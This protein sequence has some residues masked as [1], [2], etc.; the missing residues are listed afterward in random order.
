MFTRAAL[1][2]SALLVFVAAPL[3]AADTPPPAK[4]AAG[5]M[6]PDFSTFD[7]AGKEVRLADY[8]GKVLILDFWAT[9]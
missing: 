2:V 3:L 5:V 9:W 1:A 4:L 8:R 7:L 6:A